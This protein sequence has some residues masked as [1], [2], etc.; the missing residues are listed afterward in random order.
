MNES[1]SGVAAATWGPGR[2]DLFWRAENGE[3]MH[4]AQVRGEWLETESL[5]GTLV[6]N[7]AATAWGVDQLEVFAVFPDGEL[8]DRFWD[9]RSWHEW[10]SLGGELERR[11]CRV[12]VRAGAARRLRAGPRRPGLAPLV[13]RHA[14]GRV[15]ATGPLSERIR[16]S[17]RL[18]WNQ[19]TDWPSLL[20]A[21]R[22][23]ERL[24]FDTLWTWDHLYPI[25]GSSTGPMF[26]ALAA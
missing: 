17:G 18:C 20:E 26:E 15:G 1:R 8:W 19:Y 22:R 9:G 2:L 24:G 12:L 16:D 11:S 23:A 7:P 21:G 25:V 13:G 6:S 14:L 3:L 5:G 4:R 10:E